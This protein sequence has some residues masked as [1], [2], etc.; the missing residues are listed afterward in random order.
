MPVEE[1]PTLTES[2]IGQTRLGVSEATTTLGLQEQDAD[3]THDLVRARSVSVEPDDELEGADSLVDDDSGNGFHLTKNGNVGPVTA[4]DSKYGPGGVSFEEFGD[5]LS[6]DD[7]AFELIGEMAY[8]WVGRFDN[9]QPDPGFAVVIWP[10]VNA[11]ETGTFT[12]YAKLSLL[13]SG[14]LRFD[15]DGNSF[16]DSSLTVPD[17]ETIGVVARRDS[18][19]DLQVHVWDATNGWREFINETGRDAPLGQGTATL[20]I[21]GEPDDD[22]TPFDRARADHVEVYK[23]ASTPTIAVLK[24]RADPTTNVGGTDDPNG[25]ELGL[26]QL[27]DTGLTGPFFRVRH[28]IRARDSEVQPGEEVGER[29]IVRPRQAG[30]TAEDESEDFA[31]RTNTIQATPQAEQEQTAT[32]SRQVETSPVDE[33]ERTLQRDRQTDFQTVDEVG[34]RHLTA[35]RQAKVAPMAE[36]EQTHLREREGDVTPTGEAE[37]T[38]QR[39]RQVDT[40]PTDEIGDRTLSRPRQAGATAEDESEDLQVSTRQAG[41]TPENEQEFAILSRTRTAQATPVAE[42]G[43]TT[44]VRNRSAETTPASERGERHHIHHNQ[45]KSTPAD[46]QETTHTRHNHAETTPS[47][48]REQTIQRDRQAETAPENGGGERTIQRDRQAGAT[49]EDESEDLQIRARQAGVAPEDSRKRNM[50]SRTRT[51]QATPTDEQETTQIR[52]RHALL[53]AED[54][55]KELTV[56]RDRQV[57]VTAEQIRNAIELMHHNLAVATT[58]TEEEVTFLRSRL[59][60]VEEEIEGSV[61]KT[62]IDFDLFDAHADDLQYFGPM[63]LREIYAIHIQNLIDSVAVEQRDLGD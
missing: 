5:N 29:H 9:I 10:L 19:N 49:A 28:L 52:N 61:V 54:G 34:E 36:Q 6:I 48:E 55:G 14:K 27:E 41:V 15:D 26:Y 47:S 63:W 18:N 22:D 2:V 51:A 30:S 57:A 40:T 43:E 60:Q 23:G 17:G 11:K 25:N 53:S 31:V 50:L 32:R 4:T 59:A 12:R 46:E 38:L 45:A 42:E 39:D 44:H 8:V 62:A 13:D 33:Q 1:T 37:R 58:G 24:D 16:S 56:Q 21:G 3:T 35:S 20:F 7:V